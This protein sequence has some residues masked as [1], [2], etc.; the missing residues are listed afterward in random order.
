MRIRAS[1]LLCVLCSLAMSA[2]AW[3]KVLSNRF[4]FDQAT[5]ISGN[6]LKAGKYR[7]L[8][9]ESTGLVKVMRNGKLVAK[10]KGQWVNLKDKSQYNEVMSKRNNIQEVR[11]AGKTR[12][13]KFPA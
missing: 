2:P 7:F 10:V 6:H 5:A 11:F 4:E 9:N 12:A 8:A 1:L 13:I 3:A